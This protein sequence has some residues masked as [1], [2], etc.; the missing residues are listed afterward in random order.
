[1]VMVLEGFAL[2]HNNRKTP[3]ACALVRGSA[4]TG[5]EQGRGLVLHW[6]VVGM[7][8]TSQGSEENKQAPL[9]A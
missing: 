1:M 8:L 9:C 2:V 7:S 4:K 5:G 3:S 6:H